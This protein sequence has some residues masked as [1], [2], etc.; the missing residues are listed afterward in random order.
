IKKNNW[1]LFFLLQPIFL[2]E[3]VVAGHFD[4]LWLIFVLLA[5]IFAEKNNWAFVIISLTI[6]IWIKFLP[7]FVVPWFALW[8]YQNINRQNWIKNIAQ[9]IIGLFSSLVLSWLVWYKYWVGFEVFNSILLQSKWAVNSLFTVLYYSLKPLF[10]FFTPN[11]HIYLTS[12]V[13]GSLLIFFLYMI[14]PLIKGI[15][16]I[17]LKKKKWDSSKYILATFISLLAYL[18]IWQK[19]FWPWYMTWI[20]P[21]G[22]LSFLLFENKLTKNIIIWISTIPLFFYIPQLIFGDN[23]TYLL[24]YYFVFFVILLYPLIQLFKWR[25]NNYELEI[26]KTNF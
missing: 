2:L 22:I 23:T 17:L 7:V 15:Y 24:F 9:V 25:K 1:Y 20:L 3:W 21:F 8:F 13:Q 4:G 26:D 6:G 19:S 16:V 18:L 5:F 10:V 14:Y 12:L 11:F